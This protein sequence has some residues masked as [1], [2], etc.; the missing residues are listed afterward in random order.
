MKVL[1]VNH[2]VSLWVNVGMTYVM[3]TLKREHDVRLFDRMEYKKDFLFSLLNYIQDFSPDLICFSVNS[4][5]INDAI[6]LGQ[7][8][9]DDFPN[10]EIHFGGVH[11]TILPEETINIACVDSISIGEGEMSLLEYLR[12][13]P[14]RRN[15]PVPGIWYKTKYGLIVR[16]K[17]RHFVEDLD[18]L[19]FPDWSFWDID[20]YMN[21]GEIT[22]GTLRV[23]SSRGC[24]FECSFCSNPL[25]MKAQ[26]GR[27][28]RYRSP[29]KIIEE[30][31]MNIEKYS[32]RGFRFLMI[33]DSIFGLNPDQLQ[34][35]CDL[36]R[37]KGLHRK[38]PWGAQIRCGTISSKHAR[39]MREAGCVRINLSIESGNDHMRNV[40][41][42]K[43]IKK[44]QII[45]SIRMF[46][47]EGI[48]V[49]AFAMIGGPSDTA[50][51]FQETLDLA[52]SAGLSI[53]DLIIIRYAPLPMTE[54]ARNLHSENLKGCFQSFSYKNATGIESSISCFFWMKLRILKVIGFLRNGL[55]LRGWCFFRDFF[56]LFI[57]NKNNR[58][59]P[60]V[61]LC[62]EQR[63]VNELIVHHQMCRVIEDNKKSC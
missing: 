49:R 10:I 57:R 43:N 52:K 37:R 2:N 32:G 9:K 21:E 61:Y 26:P 36:Y 56:R 8:I 62:S 22:P 25:F 35:F 15:D 5:T 18:S 1:F 48:V 39:L 47:E 38:M 59:I 34:S 19:P 14:H 27:Y 63:I 7:R 11:P 23:L 58:F 51:R 17:S 44:E 53:T 4:Y 60:M 13:Q 33:S 50:Q 29:E 3:T 42:K 16:S 55:K 46:R 54:L 24:P 28:Y 12:Q 30:I 45:D 20:A 40:I 31:E 6:F 41:Y